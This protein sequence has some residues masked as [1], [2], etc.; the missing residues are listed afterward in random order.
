MLNREILSV[1]ESMATNQHNAELATELNKLSEQLTS[2]DTDISTIKFL[3]GINIVSIKQFLICLGISGCINVYAILT[4]SIPLNPAGLLRLFVY[5]AIL[6]LWG[7]TFAKLFNVLVFD[8]MVISSRRDVRV[9][10]Y[11]LRRGYSGV[12]AMR[13]LI[14]KTDMW[15]APWKQNT[16]KN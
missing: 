2:T 5:F 14:K 10:F 13:F 9:A 6:S 1:A 12:P 8:R 7:F 11:A 3:S 15:L 4:L 16:V